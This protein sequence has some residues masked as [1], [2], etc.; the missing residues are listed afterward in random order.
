MTIA[1]LKGKRVSSLPVERVQKGEPVVNLKEAKE[2]NL[3]VPQRF[4]KE[5]QRNGVFTDEFDRICNWSRIIMGIIR[6]RVIF[7]F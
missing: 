3:Q 4:L 2:L 7:N 5:C 6:L 1:I